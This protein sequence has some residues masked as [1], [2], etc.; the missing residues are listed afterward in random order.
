MKPERLALS[1]TIAL[2]LG[3]GVAPLL[4]MITAS[5]TVDGGFSLAHYQTLFTA[6]RTWR[7]LGRSLLLASL[8]T[9]G[10]ALLGVPLGMPGDIRSCDPY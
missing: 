2:L 10:A 5:V 7:L 6:E 8:T 4:A 1:L 9:L 3:L